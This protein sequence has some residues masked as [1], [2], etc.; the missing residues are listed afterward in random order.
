M[1]SCKHDIRPPY[2]PQLGNSASKHLQSNPRLHFGEN[3]AIEEGYLLLL[4]HLCLPPPPL[5]NCVLKEKPQE[6]LSEQHGGLAWNTLAKLGQEEGDSHYY[7]RRKQLPK[8]IRRLQLSFISKASQANAGSYCPTSAHTQAPRTQ[9]CRQAWAPTE[10]GGKRG[11][12]L[13]SLCGSR[14]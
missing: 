6:K 9:A 5:Y 12:Q 14:A 4:L 1:P 11:L 3:M 10:L 13:P 7:R 2:N 8:M